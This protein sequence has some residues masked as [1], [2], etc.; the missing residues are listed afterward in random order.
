MKAR[1]FIG[2]ALLMAGML[3][4]GCGGTEGTQVE[5]DHLATSEDPIPDCTNVYSMTT[6]YSDAAKTNVV[7]ERGCDCGAWIRWGS[8]SGYYDL[9]SGTCF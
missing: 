1:H 3:M 6:Y 5:E 2:S 8:T 9:Y 4:V 7:G